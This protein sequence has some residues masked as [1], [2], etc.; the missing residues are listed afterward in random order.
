[1]N[2]TTQA[3]PA[4]VIIVDDQLGFRGAARLLLE[5]RGYQVVA[6][7]ESAATAVAAVD[8]HEPSAVLLDVRLGDDDGMELCGVLT[9]A[10]PELAVLLVSDGDY[11]QFT[12]L[13][14][15]SGARGFVSKSRLVHVDFGEFWPH[16]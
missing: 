11:E 9:R 8:L 13:I 15:A 3:H 2:V 1:V 6:E 4:R 16:A 14:A 10:R 12:D 5:A 7:A